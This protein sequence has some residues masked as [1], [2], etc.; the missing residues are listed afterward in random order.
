MLEFF[1]LKLLLVS[2]LCLTKPLKTNHDFNFKD[3]KMLV[4]IQNKTCRII[5]E[6]SII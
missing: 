1:K 6:F 3:S 4:N 2:K 5:G